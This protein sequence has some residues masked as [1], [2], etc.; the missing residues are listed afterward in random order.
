MAYIQYGCGYSAPEGWLNFDSSP[1][2]KLEKLPV[3]GRL[4]RKNT[5]RFPKEIAVGDIVRGLPVP[6]NSADGVYAS[7]ILEHLSRADIEVALRNTFLMLKPGGIFRLIV[8]D[9]EARVRMY[10]ERL[11]A[12]AT[13]ANDW[14]MRAAHLGLPR[15][16]QSATEKVS[17]AFGGSLHL[18]M[19]DYASMRTQ[20]ERAGFADIRRCSLGDSGDPMFERVENP[21]R[22]HDSK[23]DIVE[24]AIQARKP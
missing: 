22:F 3:I 4:V 19:W 11:D 5:T 13:D 17:H 16:P 7:H 6:D 21:T 9:L 2:I 12:G 18:W 14:F 24:L 20:L 23:H 10:I 1:T 8:P 15:R